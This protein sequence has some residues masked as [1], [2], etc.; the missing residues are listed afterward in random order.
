[1]KIFIF[2]LKDLIFILYLKLA[3]EKLPFPF[4]TKS[5]PSSVDFGG[6]FETKSVAASS[7]RQFFSLLTA[8]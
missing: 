1:M 6:A 4:T 7:A 8:V 2:S 5:S 3:S